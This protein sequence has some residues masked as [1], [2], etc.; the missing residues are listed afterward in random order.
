MKVNKCFVFFFCLIAL[1]VGLTALDFITAEKG[2]A[3]QRH[4]TTW[5]GKLAFGQ[6]HRDGQYTFYEAVTVK[7]GRFIQG[8]KLAT[9]PSGEALHLH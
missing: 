2:P 3:Y 5:N 8:R 9:L 6:L 4:L 7:N 1:F